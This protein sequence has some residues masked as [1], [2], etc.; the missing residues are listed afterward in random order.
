[1]TRQ[2]NKTN[3]NT[4]TSTKEKVIS[5]TAASPKLVEKDSLAIIMKA[6]QVIRKD[7]LEHGNSWQFS[8]KFSDYEPPPLTYILCKHIIQ[9]TQRIETN[10][11]K[12]LLDR[13]AS[14]LAQ[15]MVQAYKT[16][17]QVSYEPKNQSAN[18]GITK[19]TSLS[20]A[21]QW[22]SACLS[23]NKYIEPMK[24]EN[25]IATAVCKKIIERGR[26]Y[27][28]PFAVKNKPVYFVQD[29]IDFDEAA[30]D[31]TNTLHRTI[32]VMFQQETDK[33]RM[34][35]EIE[36]D[37][38][39]IE[40]VSLLD[41]DV[42]LSQI[43]E[44]ALMKSS[45]ETFSEYNYF[46]KNR[47]SQVYETHKENAATKNLIWLLCYLHWQLKENS[48]RE[49]DQE[50][51][52]PASVTAGNQN[53]FETWVAFNSLSAT[54]KA[55]KTNHCVIGPLMRSPPTSPQTLYTALCLTQKI[56]VSV[57]GIH[58]R[59]VITLDLDL[60][61][62][63]VKIRGNTGHRNSWVSRMGELHI[64]FALLGSLGRYI[65]GSGLDDIWILKGL[66]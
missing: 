8:G 21:V 26:V 53:K 9:G 50:M 20:V 40:T 12:D 6:S 38:K 7:I 19:E 46:T 54:E 49:G 33:A 58:R 14:L 4:F 57:V 42:P 5:Q 56:N 66:F 29:N 25:Q 22:L 59:T 51:C 41:Y 30:P 65:E 32:I 47:Q 1:M 45:G 24:L 55:S 63:A 39:I 44:T 48:S 15:Y 28:P 16:D 52:N 64:M 17:R 23:F 13:S 60:Y 11:Q 18:F 27:L 3:A 61:E 37:P 62:R 10:K 35:N 34:S 43:S 2:Q 36:I 31:G